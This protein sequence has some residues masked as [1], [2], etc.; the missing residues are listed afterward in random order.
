MTTVEGRERSGADLEWCHEAVQNVSR[1]FAI[2][3]NELNPPMS[4]YICVG[5]LLC[6]IP[7]TVE[8]TDRIPASE[9]SDLLRTYA[10]VFD[11]ES[12]TG[13][14][15]FLA[16]VD[17]W[18]PD[19][20][21]ADWRVV[22]QTTRVVETF[23][24]LPADARELLRAPVVELVEG[25]AEF[26]DRYKEAGGLR[27]RSID[28]LEEYCW[29]AAGTVGRFI[30]DLTVRDADPEAAETMRETSTSFANLLQLV[31]VA[32][33]VRGDFEEENNVYLPA[34]WLNEEGVEPEKV[35]APENTTRVARVI[36]RV[37]DRAAG[38]L[39]DTEAYL[40]AMPQTR[41]NTL[42]AWA[43]PCML[44]VGTIRELRERPEEVLEGGVK[45]SRQEVYAIRKCFEEGVE[46][47][48]IPDLRE[49]IADGPY[50]G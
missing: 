40:Q 13:T 32:K 41:G 2:T 23:R 12:S 31:N 50:E 20:D 39:D 5:Y 38:Y 48:D 18:L 14:D 49:E 47:E 26:V 19:T 46:P 42:S 33:D 10:S 28:E 22:E 24:S 25:M 7:D 3:I 45:I 9:Q 34:E 4:D 27:I 30:T 1:T 6:R 35:T 37:T 29:Y 36:Q 15:D 43:I 16:A 44:A 17:P 8:D 21:S 11:D